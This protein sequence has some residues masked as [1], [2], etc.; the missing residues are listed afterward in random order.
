MRCV[1]ANIFRYMLDSDAQ[2]PCYRLRPISCN[3]PGFNES[4]LEDREKAFQEWAHEIDKMLA[5][6]INV[7]SMELRDTYLTTVVEQVSIFFSGKKS[8]C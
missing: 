3:I 7:F 4:S 8:Q 1:I 6:L 5:V 2:P